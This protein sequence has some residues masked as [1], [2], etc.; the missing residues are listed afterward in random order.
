MH[1]RKAGERGSELDPPG[2][3]PSPQLLSGDPVGVCR[4]Q[5]GDVLAG[6]RRG[7]AVVV[8][9]RQ[10]RHRVADALPVQVRLRGEL[11]CTCWTDRRGGGDSGAL[12]E[13][14]QLFEPDV[15]HLVGVTEHQFRCR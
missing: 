6:S 8:G 5:C 4:Q 13:E 10:G 15:A 11:R 12:V 2:G 14:H 3:E 7:V 9:C 1:G